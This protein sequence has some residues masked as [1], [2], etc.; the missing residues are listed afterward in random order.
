V[1]D[2]R[3][4]LLGIKTYSSSAPSRRPL[5][6]NLQELQQSDSTPRLRLPV[7]P[8]G[9][10]MTSADMLHPFRFVNYINIVVCINHINNTFNTS[11]RYDTLIPTSSSCAIFLM[12]CAIIILN[13]I[14]QYYHA[15]L[16]FII[17]CNILHI[18]NI[19]YIMCNTSSYIIIIIIIITRLLHTLPNC[20]C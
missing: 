16:P 18:L 11:N 2:A 20:F 4:Y 14:L 10:V 12:S 19:L 8:A 17:M 3:R 15:T 6:K 7:S 9:S 13:I 5:Q 1:S